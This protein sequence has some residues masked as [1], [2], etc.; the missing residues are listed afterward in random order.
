MAA[1]AARFASGEP[2]RAAGVTAGQAE[3]AMGSGWHGTR[4]GSLGGRSEGAGHRA[5]APGTPASGSAK[6]AGQRRPLASTPAGR[7]R[8]R[9]G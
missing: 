5:P 9:A 2:A 1:L 4:A 7:L 8:L 6:L 3:A